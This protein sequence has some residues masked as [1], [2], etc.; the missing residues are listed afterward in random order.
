VEAG[1]AGKWAAILFEL[2]HPVLTIR[3]SYG[4]IAF[5]RLDWFPKLYS[6]QEGCQTNP[7]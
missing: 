1:H 5:A 6:T 4:E 3:C 2:L 7:V